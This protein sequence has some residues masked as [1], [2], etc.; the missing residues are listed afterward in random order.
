MKIKIE[1]TGDMVEAII[2]KDLTNHLH[3]TTYKQTPPI[4]SFDEEE[5]YEKVTELRQAFKRVLDF[6]GAKQ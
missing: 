2:I 4:F 5:E 1:I 3:Y 6:Y